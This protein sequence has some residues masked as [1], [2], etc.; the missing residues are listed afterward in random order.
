[1]LQQ[2][3]GLI[4]HV[5]AAEIVSISLILC[6]A[7]CSRPP[8]NEKGFRVN[9]ATSPQSCEDNNRDVVA[10]ATG[11]R[12]ARL[13]SESDAP[14]A[15]ITARL[16]EIMSYRAIKIVYVQANSEVPWGEFVELVDHAWP[17]VNVVSVLTSRVEIPARR[18]W[19]SALS[20]KDYTGLGG[21]GKRRQ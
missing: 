4:I 20:G 12:R 8:G 14:I 3:G 13:D 15:E 10:V 6:C 21:F 7:A 18:N 2:L 16:H 17:E 9:V 11:E 19:C 1:M 5:R